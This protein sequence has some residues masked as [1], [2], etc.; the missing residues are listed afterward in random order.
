[1]IDIRAATP[2]DADALA[3]LRWEFRAPRATPTESH[4]AFRR[5]CAEWM[6][7]ELESGRWRAWVAIDGDRIVGQIWM[8]FMSKIPNPSA[9]L[10]RHAYI[11]NVYV[12]PGSRGGVGTR[13]LSAAIGAAKASYVDSVVLWPT[14]QSRSLYLRHGFAA[15]GAALTLKFE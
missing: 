15:D 3:E 11:S 5:R 8:H 14:E 7:S 6:R 1:M 9:E 12:T 2:G 4:E 10:E 13:L